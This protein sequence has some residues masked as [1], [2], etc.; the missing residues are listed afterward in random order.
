MHQ[1]IA[2]FVLLLSLL[3]ASCFKKMPLNENALLQE[4]ACIE[5]IELHDY[6]RA[7]THCELCLEF[8]KTSKECL[9]GIGLLALNSNDEEKAIE[10][11]TRAL[12][13]NNDFSQARNNLGV[14]Y[15]SRGDFEESLKYFERA[16]AIDPANID[17]RN[18]CAL[19]HVRLA[20]RFKAKNHLKKTSFHWERALEQVHKLLALDPSYASAYRDWGV[21]ELN[22]ADLA[23]FEKEKHRRL[24]VAQKAF[25]QC[26]S[27]D[28]DND[29]CF[30]GLAQVF[31]E[32]GHY[33]KAF[34][35]YFAC[36]SHAP[37][38][39]SCRSGI[40]QS[41]EKS[42]QAEGGYQQ[43][44]KRMHADP[45]NARAHDAF[46][47]A[48]FERGL[49]A[50]AQRECETALA[51]DPGLCSAHYRLADHYAALLNTERAIH[52]CRAF[53]VCDG[54]KETQEHQNKCREILVSLKL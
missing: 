53:L 40:V 28:Q 10:H 49:D 54:S 29:G 15:F 17:A 35:N 19:S 47:H 6:A 31:H 7:L 20:Q 45:K 5:S 43:F 50:E 16:L 52:H 38:N 48:L 26:L 37:K 25:E 42:A 51:L 11:F 18:N 33:D 22:R 2:V 32:Q 44:R 9:N 23:D 39:S 41:F 13:Q 14:I 30:E 34:A 21:I 3:L 8:D 12:R 1:R 24:G 4:R 36:L 27:V 46:C